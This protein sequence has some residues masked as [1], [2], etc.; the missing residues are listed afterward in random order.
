M[1]V[2]LATFCKNMHLVIEWIIHSQLLIWPASEVFMIYAELSAD[3]VDLLQTE[4]YEAMLTAGP[5][6]VPSQTYDYADL[7]A[8]AA[9]AKSSATGQGG[10]NTNN[11]DS[12]GNNTITITMAMTT[13][14]MARE[15]A[16]AAVRS[17]VAMA[18]AM[19]LAMV[20]ATVMATEMLNNG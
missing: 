5:D 2:V 6:I 12:N 7:N 11:G 9:S 1:I 19:D 20:R 17:M 3:Y 8:F 14:A 4:L 15:M 16:I 13:M 10:T 18:M